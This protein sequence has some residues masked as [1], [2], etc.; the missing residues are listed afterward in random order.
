MNT[1]PHINAY[2]FGCIDIDG[3]TYT[4]DVIILPGQ[5]QADWWRE[6]GHALKPV[7]LSAVLEA[8]PQVLVVGQGAY[9]CMRV[10]PATV[11]WLRE[12][13]IE[14]VCGKTPQAVEAYDERCKGSRKVAAALHLTC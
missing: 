13:G 9:G 6:E 12:A 4:A 5:V 3:R 10:P 2:S 11:A 8:S 7:D 14:V 1:Q